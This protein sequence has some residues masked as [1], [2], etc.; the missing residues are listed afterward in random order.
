MNKGRARDPT[1]LCAEIFQLSVMG[2]DLK[3]SILEM[4][5]SIKEEGAIPTILRESIVTTIPKTGSQFEKKK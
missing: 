4:L 1:G 5:N 2:A 3:S